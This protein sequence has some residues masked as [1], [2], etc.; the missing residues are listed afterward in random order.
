MRGL[1]IFYFGG[2]MTQPEKD[3]QYET[4]EKRDKGKDILKG[5]FETDMTAA[6]RR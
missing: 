3:A 5:M 6:D 4:T 2:A 1:R